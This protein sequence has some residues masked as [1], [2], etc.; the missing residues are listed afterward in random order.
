MSQRE[1]PYIAPVSVPPEATGQ[2][3][4]AFPPVA[5][6]PP[7]AFAPSGIYG[8][9]TPA[10]PPVVPPFVPPIYM[11][12]ASAGGSRSSG[13]WIALTGI[14]SVLVVAALLGGF[15]IGRSTR[16]ANN[17]V[18][19]KINQQSQGDQIAQQHA[20]D[21]LRND[22]NDRTAVRVRQV[23]AAAEKRGKSEGRA[24]GRQTGFE[25]GHK[26]GYTEGQSAGFASGQQA[27]YSQGLGDGTCVADF[28]YC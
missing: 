19:T 21:G 8:Y 27:G 13:F 3:T 7:M 14:V 25:A 6:G 26:A 11:G 17:D 18:Q 20:L 28:F 23:S 12:P 24:E 1:Q 15:F 9:A 5:P 16:L 10:G 2:T 22:L 4:A